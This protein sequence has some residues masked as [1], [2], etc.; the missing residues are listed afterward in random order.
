MKNLSKNQIYVPGIY[1]G[2]GPLS[3][4]LF[5]QYLLKVCHEEYEAKNDQDYPV[6]ILVNASSTPDRTKH[7]LYNGKTP[8]NH[9]I[10]FSS[11]IE[12]AGA[13]FMV[14]IC[15]TAHSY[16]K[17][18]KKYINIPWINMIDI[19][20]AYIKATMPYINKIGIMATDGTLHSRLYHKTLLN[21]NLQ[22]ISPKIGSALQQN[23]MS[24][25]YDV[26]YGI[27]TTGINVSDFAKE[28]NIQSAK[29]LKKMGA[30]A[31]I[32]G[33]TEISLCFDSIKESILP[34]INPLY[35]TA[36][37]TINL[38]FGKNLI[39]DNFNYHLPIFKDLT[40]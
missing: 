39:E 38:S 16:Y 19:T 14:I 11:L 8:I 13:D 37:F 32:T 6:W 5:E 9:L 26:H 1:G 34:V 35:I 21:N 10:Y 12:K 33:C 23:I 24:S 20:V 17:E 28:K 29:E 25:I 15:N 27:K 7:L 2:V 30:E 18:V 36:K 4:I 3:H 22:P 31:I 40:E